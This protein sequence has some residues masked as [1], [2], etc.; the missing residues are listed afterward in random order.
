[1]TACHEVWEKRKEGNRKARMKDGH[2]EEQEKTKR[3]KGR[4]KE[5]KNER[6]KETQM[7]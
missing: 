1:V 3:K 6:E 5:K 2:I 7:N 4:K